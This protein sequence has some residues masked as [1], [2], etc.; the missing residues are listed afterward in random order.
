MK[1]VHGATRLSATDLSNHLDCAHLT[2]VQSLR[3]S[4]PAASY[5][6][7]FVELSHP[8]CVTYLTGLFCYLCARYRPPDE[9]RP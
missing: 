9:P 7:L 3:R 1:T 5:P 6:I 4:P 8:L 2:A